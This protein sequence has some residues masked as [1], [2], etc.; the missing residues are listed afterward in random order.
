[1]EFTA[2]IILAFI[3]AEGDMNDR[4]EVAMDH[5]FLPTTDGT[6][7]TFLGI[8][9]L[10]LAFPDFQFVVQHYFF[11]YLL[12]VVLGAINGLIFLPALLAVCGPPSISFPPAGVMEVGIRRGSLTSPKEGSGVR[13][14][15]ASLDWTAGP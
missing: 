6:I 11:V 12:I 5:M 4:M 9:M 7:S 13:S 14:S 2:H 8:V 10:A 15:G 1:V 3:L